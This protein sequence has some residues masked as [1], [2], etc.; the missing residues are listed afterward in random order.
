M[1]NMKS[2]MKRLLTN[3]KSRVIHKG[4][5]TAIKTTEKKLRAAVESDSTQAKDLLTQS[6]KTLDKAVKAGTIH[7]NKASRKKSQFQKLLAAKK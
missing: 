6:F 7:K 4:R 1:P 2:A 5:R 3:E